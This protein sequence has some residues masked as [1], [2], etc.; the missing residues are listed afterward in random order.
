MFWKIDNS[1]TRANF[2]VRHMR[3]SWVRGSF[4]K[5]EGD[6]EFDAQNPQA[7]R[8]DVKILAESINTGDAQRD[9]HLKSPDFLNVEKYPYLTFKSKK[10]EVLDANHAKLI[11][12][13]TIR[14]ITREV[15]LD[16]EYAG[17]VKNPWG[18]TSVGFT[19][20]TQINRK[21]WN[22]TWNVALET[23]GVLVGDMVNITIELE[24]VQQASPESA[25]A[26]YA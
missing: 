4:D 17:M 23:G 11:G 6:I 22:L 5:I 2:A 14:D 13:L 7:T 26:A 10:V 3:I 9:A 25:E 15:V 16:V 21:D 19:A 24:L 20:V 12:D 18:A 8:V 1:H